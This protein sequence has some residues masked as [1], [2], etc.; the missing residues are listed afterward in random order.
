MMDE[1]F[2]ETII[3]TEVETE[4]AMKIDTTEENNE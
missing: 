3:S 2:I 1:Q 4:Y